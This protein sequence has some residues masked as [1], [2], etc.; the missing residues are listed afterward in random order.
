MKETTII[1]RLK[2]T[3]KEKLELEAE[4]QGV[5]LSQL[6]RQRV[7]NEEATKAV[8]KNLTE[9]LCGLMTEVRRL[10]EENPDINLQKIEQEA[11]KLW[12]F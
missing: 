12:E 7:V 10:G 11:A 6:I 1:C 2:A 9:I 4:R 3:E 8:N 5:T